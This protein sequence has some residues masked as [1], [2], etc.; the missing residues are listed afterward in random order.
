MVPNWTQKER[1]LSVETPLGPNKLLLRSFTGH[2]GVSQLFHFQLDLLSENPAIDFDAV[3]GQNITFATALPGQGKQ[4]YFNGYVIRFTQLPSEER[5]TR[6]H[7]VVVPWLWFLTRTQDCRIFQN[8]SVPDIVEQIFKD[9][10]FQ[11]YELQLQGSYNPLEYCVQYRET[12]FHFVSRLLE[13]EGIFYFFRHENGKHTMVL[14][15]SPS[16]HVNCPEKHRFEFEAVRVRGDKRHEDMVRTWHYEQA[17]RSGQYALGD[18]DFEMPKLRLEATAPSSINVGGNNKFEIFDYPG[19]YQSLSEG[20]RVVRVRMEEEEAAHTVI[21]GESDCRTFASGFKFELAGHERRDQ[22]G[23][24]VLLAVTHAADEAGFY[25][26][27]GSPTEAGY[28]NSFT[29]IPAAVQFRPPRVT[30]KAVIHGSQ[31]AFVV[32]P[33]G[34]EI[35][36]DK[37][38][39]VKV[40]FH[41]DRR[42]GMDDKS[43][44]WIRVAQTW[45]GNGWGAITIPRI[46][47][48]VI[49]D[50]LEG[51][52]DR[53][54]ITGCVYNGLNRPP[55]DLPNRDTM[56]GL[57]SYS[58]KGGEGYNE[59]RFEDRKGDEQ[60]VVHAQTDFV[61]RIERDSIEWIGEDRN[62]IVARDQ[63]VEVR[64]DNHLRTKGDKNEEV[65]G[66]VSRKAGGDLQE[67]TSG[68]YAMDASSEIHLKAGMTAVMEAGTSLTIKVGG[69]FISI[70]PG[71]I[72]I[73]G[74]MV[75]INSG[76]SAGSGSGSSP[77]PPKEPREP[78]K[79]LGGEAIEQPP[80]AKPPKPAVY[81]KQAVAL[82]QAAASGAPFCPV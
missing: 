11:D 4:R 14:A 69:N 15:D 43:S 18:Y 49:V 12:A 78:E 72:F 19:E 44:C 5:L 60:I 45:A 55:Y 6:Y 67:K 59:I 3:L 27:A 21:S 80:A 8:K 40:Q 62:A 74:T 51:N 35:Y 65:T 73:K 42:G 31:T 75:M 79:E 9:F 37:H 57:K 32:G 52:P 20:D 22:N 64:G 36:T 33:S 56:T 30:P 82:K 26:G 70:N 34:E 47:Q 24:Y 53:P 25:S 23:A 54:I 68:N 66:T 50:F 58:S 13:Q 48:E 1:F 77:Q 7:A 71:G 61:S 46:G 81:S 41:W 16:A 17:M 39:R 29:A 28:S 38:G 2:E 76:G 10:G 63:F